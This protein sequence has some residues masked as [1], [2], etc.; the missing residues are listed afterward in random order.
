M[1]WPR[2]G[3]PHLP[4]AGSFALDG[5]SMG[6]GTS[7]FPSLASGS[8]NGK[9]TMTMCSS[10][11]TDKQKFLSTVALSRNEQNRFLNPQLKNA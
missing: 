2:R 9:I 1:Q 6:G 5:R 11:P 3:S 7:D 8:W 4:L 10:P